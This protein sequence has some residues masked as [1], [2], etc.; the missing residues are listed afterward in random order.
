LPAS[1]ET[2]GALGDA[3][4]A[5]RRSVTLP[6]L[7]LYGL[8]TTV[9]AGIYALTGAVAGR[10]GMFAPA[11]FLLAAFLAFFTALS[12]AELSSRFPRAG[13]EA[14]YVLEGL[15]WRWLSTVVGVLVVLAGLVSA[16]TVS[17]A[18][19][20]Y[21]GEFVEVPRSLAILLAVVGIGAVAV[22][23]VRESVTAAGV[24]TV[25]EI[26]GLLAVVALGSPHFAEL[27]A[28][29]AEFIPTHF[30]AWQLVASATILCFY[31]F[32][33][34]EDMVNIAEEVRDVRRILPRAIVLTVL[35]TALLYALV[36]T[37]SVLAVSPNELAASDAPLSLVFERSGGSPAILGVVAIF[38]L[39]NGALIQIV[40]ASRVL[41]GLAREGSLPAVLGRVNSRTHTP[42]LA[43]V[44]V[45]AI[46]ALFALTF[47]LG[48][49]AETTALITLVTFTLAN[50]ALLLVKRRDPHPSG[51]TTF[52]IGVPVA[53]FAVS[54]AF[55]ML[56][57]AQRLMG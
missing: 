20:G 26:G 46:A 6:W 36:T 4:P 44:L 19:V 27:P 8:G 32:L 2:D 23:G 56:A 43:T 25:I 30:D 22:W 37:V 10:A 15:R 12:F 49:L 33:G 47:P 55:V 53:G 31:A 57:A 5:L 9:G 39:L 3:A 38:A 16:A 13:G 24:M 11:A 21:L 35:V 28:R 48:T 14:V 45:V 34:F 52:P 17:V 42:A 29:A 54:F 40:K 18:L 41:Y 1:A 51:V 7:V 50:L